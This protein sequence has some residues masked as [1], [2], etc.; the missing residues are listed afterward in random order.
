[1][2]VSKNTIKKM[3]VKAGYS[4]SDYNAMTIEDGLQ[5]EDREDYETIKDA[6]MAVIEDTPNL[7]VVS[8]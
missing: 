2:Q 5:W 1:M 6:V 4:E 8:I 7:A 3:L